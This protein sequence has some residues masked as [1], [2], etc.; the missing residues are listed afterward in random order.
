M[1]IRLETRIT[2]EQRSALV[3]LSERTGAS[4]SEITRRALIAYL[5]KRA[6][7]R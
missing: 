2:D 3:R 1:A 4:L 6:G 5:A 7:P